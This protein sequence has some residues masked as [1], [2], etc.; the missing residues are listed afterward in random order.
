MRRKEAL[1]ER[2]RK[3]GG[4]DTGR[5]KRKAQKCFLESLDQQQCSVWSKVVA[6]EFVRPF[7]LSILER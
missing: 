5:G 2:E 3:E 6:D 1:S 4:K 7:L